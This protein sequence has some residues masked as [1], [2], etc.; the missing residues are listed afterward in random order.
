MVTSSAGRCREDTTHDTWDDDPEWGI[1][2]IR[3]GTF[4]TIRSVPFLTI[5]NGEYYC[6]TDNLEPVYTA[7]L[8]LDDLV[9]AAEKVLAH[10]VAELPN[11]KPEE[12]RRLKS[13]IL[14]AAKASSWRAIVR[15]G[16]TY[17]LGWSDKGIRLDMALPGKGNGWE[18][19]PA[20]VRIFSPEAPLVDIMAV[21]LEDIKSRPEL[22]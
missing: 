22:K 10:G 6:I 19:D 5:I 15:K 13:P 11:P 12:G 4:Y 17:S 21:V 7:D 8:N 14:A 18:Y 20:K 1:P 9:S 16:T 3:S 2:T